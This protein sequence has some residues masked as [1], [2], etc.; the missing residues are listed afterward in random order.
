MEVLGFW[1]VVRVP[2]DADRAFGVVL[3]ITL[4]AVVAA[5]YA[6]A[7]CAGTCW[8]VWW[9]GLPFAQS[10]VVLSARPAGWPD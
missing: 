5:L 6:A 8:V 3:V 4:I 1:E 7:L 9:V 10:Q 2:G